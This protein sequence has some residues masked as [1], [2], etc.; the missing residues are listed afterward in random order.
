MQGEL[1]SSVLNLLNLVQ[2]RHNDLGFEEDSSL[3]L[4]NSLSTY[5]SE[6]GNALEKDDGR[7]AQLQH[8]VLDFYGEEAITEAAKNVLRKRKFDDLGTSV[9]NEFIV[10]AN[11]I[12]ALARIQITAD[13]GNALPPKLAPSASTV[14]RRGD[15][16]AARVPVLLEDAEPIEMRYHKAVRQVVNILQ[17]RNTPPQYNPSVY[18]DRED[19][20]LGGPVDTYLVLK[21]DRTAHNAVRDEHVFAPQQEVEHRS[22]S[23]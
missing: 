7:I 12:E 14:V 11:S 15:V 2:E 16:V 8:V 20:A 18:E 3:I 10:T 9:R 21:T 23:S 22:D 6:L 17:E 5:L 1:D 19:L 13:G 4:E